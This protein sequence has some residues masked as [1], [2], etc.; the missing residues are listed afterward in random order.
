MNI[1]GEGKCKERRLVVTLHDVLICLEDMFPF[2]TDEFPGP[3]GG[4]KSRYF[5]KRISFTE[6]QTFQIAMNQSKLY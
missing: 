5:F 1:A 4:N 3:E 6:K 2:I